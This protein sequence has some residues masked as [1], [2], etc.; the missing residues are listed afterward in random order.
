M[1][2]AA[3]KSPAPQ[4]HNSIPMETVIAEV[5]SSACFETESA[6]LARGGCH[7][8][9]RPRL[10]KLLENDMVR[11]VFPTESTEV[12]E[13]TAIGLICLYSIRDRSTVYAHAVFAGSTAN[14]SLRSIFNPPNQT[15]P[16]PGIEGNK[17]I[18]KFVAW[19]A[20][21]WGKFLNEE[22]AL[23][24]AEAS[25]IWLDSFWKALDRMYG[26]GNLIS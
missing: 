1:N 4:S 22:L 20:A 24:T 18:V 10:F 19:K 14:A 2:S 7:V 9:Q 12:D 15:K 26:G 21:A 8:S 3:V 13:G 23:G 17:A 11:I 16:Q 5:Q 25:R 6:W